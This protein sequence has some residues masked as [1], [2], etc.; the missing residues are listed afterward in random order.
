MRL[1]ELAERLDAQREVLKRPALVLAGLRQ[2]TYRRRD[3]GDDAQ[4]ALGADDQL[5]Q[6]GRRARGARERLDLDGSRGR[7]G[8]QPHSELV[9]PAVPGRGLAGRPGGRE[10]A[11]GRV[12]PG[13]RQ[14][15]Q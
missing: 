6:R 11:D 3:L 15:A 10:A 5:A 8:A 1:L 4:D 12:L 2:W 7:R 13:L 9:D 14:V